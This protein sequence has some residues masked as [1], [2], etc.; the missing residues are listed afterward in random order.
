[1]KKLVISCL[2]L[3][4]MLPIAFAQDRSDVK[5][6]VKELRDAIRSERQSSRGQLQTDAKAVSLAAASVTAADV[7]E[8]D[9]FGKNAQFMGIAQSGIVLID[10]TCDPVDIGPLGPDDHCITVADPSIPV[11]STTFNDIARITL[12]GKSASNIV[13]VISNNTVSFSMFNP[14][15]APTQARITYI[16]TLTIESEA[17]NDPSLINPVTGL[18]FNGS[19]TSGIGGT[20]LTNKTLAVGASEFFT[21]SYSRANTTGLS[22]AFF[23]GLGLPDNVIKEL[24]KKPMTLRLNVIVSSR[25]VDSATL[26]LT[27]RFLGN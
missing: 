17:L 15:P 9:S 1:M 8:P 19:F 6:Q 25:W 2:A 27:A 5:A 13:Y 24:Y 26:L 16:P 4:T 10:P 7:G 23:Q 12:P 21:H 20:Y 3:L 14:G 18:P 11:P 22:K